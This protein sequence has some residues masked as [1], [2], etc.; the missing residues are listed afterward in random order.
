MMLATSVHRRVVSPRIQV[1]F[2]AGYTQVECCDRCGVIDVATGGLQRRVAPGN[3]DRCGKPSVESVI[4]VR[5]ED[6][7]HGKSDEHD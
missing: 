7:N 4:P 3:N 6:N 5:S 2:T 1:V